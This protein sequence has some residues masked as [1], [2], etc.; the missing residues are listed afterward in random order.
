M[1]WQAEWFLS[2]IF[3]F[4]FL[5]GDDIRAAFYTVKKSFL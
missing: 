5:D 1:L 4:L 2:A 3:N